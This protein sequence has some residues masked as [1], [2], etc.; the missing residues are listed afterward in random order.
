ME[1]LPERSPTPNLA[2]KNKYD[3]QEIF[4]MIITVVTFEY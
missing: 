1:Y 3:N 4:A 2:L